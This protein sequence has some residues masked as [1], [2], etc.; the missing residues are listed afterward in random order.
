MPRR[1]DAT[2]PAPPARAWLVGT[3]DWPVTGLSSARIVRGGDH[4]CRI[5]LTDRPAIHSSSP[6]APDLRITAHPAPGLV[7]RGARELPASDA[8][9][10]GN[11]C[12]LLH[13]FGFQLP[14][15]HRQYLLASGFT[16]YW[17]RINIY[18]KDFMVRIVFNPVAFRLKRCPQPVALAAA[19]LV[20]FVI[21]WLLHA[22]QTF[23]L[24]GVWG[25]SAPDGLFWGILGFLV[26]FN[27]QL[28]AR[29]GQRRVEGPSRSPLALAIRAARI[30]GT[31]AG[32]GACHAFGCW[33]PGS[34]ESWIQPSTG[35]SSTWP[36]PRGSRR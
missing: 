33:F 14:E 15:T 26:L 31:F 29:R 12:G 7:R 11:A 35:G 16:D 8:R 27:V 18:W 13:L 25:F 34:V 5:K 4:V 2:G 3:D 19:T 28:D 20:V 1:P 9:V 30:V 32:P 17:R 22:Y 6:V 10:R 36:K 23:W 24:R 21:T